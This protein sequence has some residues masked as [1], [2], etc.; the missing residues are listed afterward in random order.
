[1]TRWTAS[2]RRLSILP[3]PVLRDLKKLATEVVR[4][5]SAKP[6]MARKVHLSFAKFEPLVGPSDHVAEGANHQFGAV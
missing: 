4:E 1:L 2:D 6:P 3:V 5:D